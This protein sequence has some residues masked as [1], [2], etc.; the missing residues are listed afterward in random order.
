M[1]KILLGLTIIV[2]FSLISIGVWEIVKQILYIDYDNTNMGYLSILLSS[3]LVGIVYIIW[4]IISEKST[5][6]DDKLT[7]ISIISSIVGTGLIMF[8]LSVGVFSDVWAAILIQI[9]TTI[10]SVVL[11]YIVANKL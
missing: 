2:V 10:I 7:F 6:A 8:C 11:S 9:I 4:C 1:K 5:V 3:I